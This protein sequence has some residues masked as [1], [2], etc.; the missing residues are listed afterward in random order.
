LKQINSEQA[1]LARENLPEVQALFNVVSRFKQKTGVEKIVFVESI[2]DF[3]QKLETKAD[4]IIID[5]P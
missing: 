1:R 3:Q 5:Y 4:V 2:K